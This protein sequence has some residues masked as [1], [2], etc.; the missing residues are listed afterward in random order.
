MMGSGEPPQELENVV[1][2]RRDFN[3]GN[4][5][6]PGRVAGTGLTVNRIAAWYKTGL[7]P[8]EIALEYPHSTLAQVHPALAY[9]LRQSG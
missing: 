4:S 1:G 8:E 7:T 6:N 3:L 9:D 5:C 2:P